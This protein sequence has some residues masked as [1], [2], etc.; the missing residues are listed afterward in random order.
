M[1]IQTTIVVTSLCVSEE[2]LVVLRSS[3]AREAIFKV[4]CSRRIIPSFRSLTDVMVKDLKTGECIRADHLLEDVMDKVSNMK[5]LFYE[6]QSFL[7]LD[8]I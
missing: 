7:L 5:H 3:D 4:E 8:T 2:S 1:L 6:L